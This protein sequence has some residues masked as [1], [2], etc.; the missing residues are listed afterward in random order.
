[1]TSYIIT[2]EQ[3]GNMP[4]A[5]KAHL[6]RASGGS[7]GS[8]SERRNGNSERE[9]RKGAPKTSSQKEPRKGAPKRSP[10]RELR[11]GGPKRSCERELRKGTYFGRELRRAARKG[12]CE[13]ELRK[14]ALTPKG[15]PGFSS[16]AIF[17]LW[18]QRGEPVEGSPQGELSRRALKGSSQGE[19]PRGALKGSPQGELPRGAL[20]GSS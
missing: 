19:L 13:K 4:W 10:G 3:F 7:S 1:M 12:S 2:T 15:S 8:G 11:R 18:V 17:V 6:V 20:K 9:L 16:S 5:H 14:G